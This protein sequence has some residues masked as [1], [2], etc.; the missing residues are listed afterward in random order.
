M[1]QSFG[2][3]RF[4]NGYVFRRRPRIATV[5]PTKHLARMKAPLCV[6][7]VSAIAVMHIALYP[8]VNEFARQGLHTPRDSF[9]IIAVAIMLIPSLIF[10]YVLPK[11]RVG[12]ISRYWHVPR[13]TYLLSR[14]LLF[15]SVHQ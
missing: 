4:G 8:H 7:G 12:S 1:I 14:P 10:A 2:S 13:H 11:M 3:R 9:L 15:L 6:G 5:P